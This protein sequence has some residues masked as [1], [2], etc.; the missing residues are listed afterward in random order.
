MVRTSENGYKYVDYGK[1]T[2]VLLQ[3]VK[4]QQEQIEIQQKA[5]LELKNLVQILID[6]ESGTGN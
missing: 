2:V 1:M 3:A 5:I 6:R 4:E